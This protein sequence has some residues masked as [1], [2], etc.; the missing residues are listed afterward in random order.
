MTFLFPIFLF[1]IPFL[2]YQATL[3]PLSSS[4]SE[5]DLQSFQWQYTADFPS[6]LSSN[7]PHI[8][9]CSGS[10]SIFGGPDIFQ[11]YYFIAIQTTFQIPPHYSLDF[12]FI[13]VRFGVWTSFLGMS[14][15]V[16]FD[17]WSKTLNF[18][19][20]Y[21][22]DGYFSSQISTCSSTSIYETMITYTFSPHYA[23]SV[24]FSITDTYV[25]AESFSWGITEF[26]INYQTCDAACASCTGPLNTQ[27]PT[28]LSTTVYVSGVN[29]CTFCDS[30]CLNCLGPNPTDCTICTTNNPYKLNFF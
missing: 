16:V 6:S 10:L 27:C 5:S 12:S 14:L 2:S 23:N 25:L 15:N 26:S 3:T 4:F 18:A 21:T 8:T 20:L 30:T 22:D 9:S 13:L 29:T 11:P 17:T 1:L 19:N 28:C 7:P 24:V